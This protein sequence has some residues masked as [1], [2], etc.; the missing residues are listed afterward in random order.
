MKRKMK[1][2]KKEGWKNDTFGMK[3]KEL[4]R[5]KRRGKELE[6]RKKNENKRR[7][8]RTYLYTFDQVKG[9]ERDEKKKGSDNEKKRETN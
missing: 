3:L 5:P 7:K 1:T 9:N 8:K 4:K 6:T 2:K